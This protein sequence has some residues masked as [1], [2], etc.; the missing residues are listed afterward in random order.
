MKKYI[1]LSIFAL[2]VASLATS[3]DMDSAS[4]STLDET[5]VYSIYGLAE[6]EIMSINVSFG[7]TNSYRG[8]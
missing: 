8:R 7:E 1:K 5:T 4:I 3:C 2:A 6:Q